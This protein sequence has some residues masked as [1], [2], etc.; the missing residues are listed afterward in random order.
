MN[1]EVSDVKDEAS[2]TNA[3]LTEVHKT[4]KTSQL[5]RDVMVVASV[6]LCS[7]RFELRRRI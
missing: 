6:P 2:K 4:C 7:G 3:Q 5:Q 1:R